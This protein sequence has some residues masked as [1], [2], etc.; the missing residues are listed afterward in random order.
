[1]KPLVFNILIIA[2]LSISSDSYS[3]TSLP[4]FRTVTIGGQTWM[5][6][7]LSM[8]I[9]GSRCYFSKYHQRN[10]CTR[11]GRYY[12]WEAASQL[13]D[14]IEGW[15][16][17]TNQEFEQLISHLGGQRS[18]YQRLQ[19]DGDSGFNAKLAGHFIPIT[20]P[21]NDY[22]GSEVG[23]FDNVGISGF[24]WS[25]EPAPYR[26]RR[27]CLIIGKYDNKAKVGNSYDKAK[28]S[29]RLIKE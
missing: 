20:V 12:T 28:L 3:D 9:T 21:S 1:M 7:N 16:L 24:F 17:P 6:D 19:T 2:L 29:V 18:A 10:D 26:S 25:S 5:A 8:P 4:Q 22:Y 15:R 11:Y 23:E 13:A 27:S 14:Q